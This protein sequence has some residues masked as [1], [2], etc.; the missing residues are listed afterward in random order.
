M[1]NFELDKALKELPDKK[2]ID[3]LLLKV[4]DRA[5][6]SGLDIKLFKPRPEEKRDFYAAVPVDIEASGSYHQVAT[7]FDEV[8][9]L[10][11]I[12]NLDNLAISDPIVDK[13]NVTL[14]TTVTATAFRFLDESERPQVEE[15]K[16]KKR[17]RK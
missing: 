9:H 4:S 13:K 15:Q 3:Q 2:E 8:G 5:K 7:F 1:L 17:R 14:K 6:D 11:R 16:E 12:V 10:D